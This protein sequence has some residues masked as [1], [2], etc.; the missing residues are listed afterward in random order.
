MTWLMLIELWLRICWYLLL[1]IVCCMP[2][3]WWVLI[4]VLMVMSY[5]NRDR[6]L[7]TTIPRFKVMRCNKTGQV[8]SV[9]LEIGYNEDDDTYRV[10]MRVGGNDRLPEEAVSSYGTS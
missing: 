8:Q 2:L 7:K 4:P 10:A 5:P 6:G 9:E 3:V 1:P